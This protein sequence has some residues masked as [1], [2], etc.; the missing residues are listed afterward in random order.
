M[1]RTIPSIH[2][3]DHVPGGPDP[4]PPYGTAIYEIKVYEDQNEAVVGDGA[5]YWP[6]PDDL[7]GAAIIYADAGVSTPSSSGP[8]EVQIAHQV[9]GAGAYTDVLSSTIAIA[10]GDQNATPGVV[11]GSAWPVANGDWLRIDIDASG[12]GAKGLAVMIGL[13]PATLA[14]MTIAGAKGDPG[15][16]VDWRG[17]WDSGT[18]YST[19]DSVN[20]LGSSYVAIQPSTGVEPGVTPGWEAYWQL[21]SAANAYSAVELLLD[22]GGVGFVLDPGVKGMIELPFD[23]TIVE[24][25]LFANVAGSCVVD[26]W[27]EAYG[28]YPPTV[29]DSITGAAPL[30]LTGAAKTKNTSLTG[31]TTALLA[32]DILAFNLVSCVSISQLTASLRVK[33]I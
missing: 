14:S 33:R 5:F 3:K 27:R 28:S 24:A 21:L 17:D 9:G 23:C 29:A 32:G 4:I 19:N 6:I 11:S 12:V 18:A 31:W 7:D 13:T 30:T 10:S 16:V 25:S 20:N 1:E 8:V 26:I 22:G 15:G 2:G